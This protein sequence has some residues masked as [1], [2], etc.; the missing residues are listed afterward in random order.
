MHCAVCGVRVSARLAQ[1]D[2][3]ARELLCSAHY[4]A[5]RQQRQQQRQ[6]RARQQH[7][8]TPAE[9]AAAPLARPPPRLSTD[10]PT[11]TDA[12]EAAADAASEA[13]EAEEASSADGE[14]PG[15]TVEGAART[16]QEGAASTRATEVD[17]SSRTSDSS[18]ASEAAGEQTDDTPDWLVQAEVELQAST[19]SAEEALDDWAASDLGP[20]VES[21]TATS[22]GEIAALH[23]LTMRALSAEAALT[24][25]AV[26]ARATAQLADAERA[27]AERVSLAEREAAAGRAAAALESL[28][29]GRAEARAAAALAAA[30][31]S[32]QAAAAERA[33]SQQ[34]SSRLA[35]AE[36]AMAALAPGHDEWRAGKGEAPRSA[37]A[38]GARRDAGMTAR[39]IGVKEEAAVKISAIERAAAEREAAANRVVEETKRQISHREQ[40]MA[41]EKKEVAI[42]AEERIAAAQRKASEWALV[43]V[44]RAAAAAS[45]RIAAEKAAAEKARV[46]QVKAQVAAVERAA[47]AMVAEREAAALRRASAAE[48]A[49][50]VARRET[51]DAQRLAAAQMKALKE[52]AAG[53]LE[54]RI[55]EVQRLALERVAAVEKAA[56]SRAAAMER[57]EGELAA[58]RAAAA[59]AAAAE[60]DAREYSRR[61][62]SRARAAEVPLIDKFEGASSAVSSETRV[63]ASEAQAAG[64]RL[65]TDEQ[66]ALTAEAAAALFAEHEAAAWATAAAAACIEAQG[67]LEAAERSKQQAPGRQ[68]V[69][70]RV[71]EKTAM[72]LSADAAALLIAEQDTETRVGE[73]STVDMA[74]ALR[75]VVQILD[76]LA[77]LLAT[78]NANKG[79]EEY[80]AWRDL[81]TV[82]DA[83]RQRPRDYP[84]GMLALRAPADA[85]ARAL[86]GGETSAGPAAELPLLEYEEDAPSAGGIDEWMT[87]MDG[88]HA[89]AVEAAAEL[90]AD[91]EAPAWATAAA[92]LIEAQEAAEGAEQH[93][94]GRVDM[95]AVDEAAASPDASSAG[96][97]EETAMALSAGVAALLMAEE[98]GEAKVGE[99]DALDV[100]AALTLAVQPGEA[101]AE[102][103]EV[104]SMGDAQA[105]IVDTVAVEQHTLT[106]EAAAALFAEREAFAWAAAA[107][108][109]IEAQEGLEAAGAAKHQA[110]GGP[111][112]GAVSAPTEGPDAVG[113]GVD[114]TASMTLAAGVAALLMAEEDAGGGA[115][116]GDA[117]DEAGALPAA[118]EVELSVEGAKIARQLDEVKTSSRAEEY[119]A[120]RDLTTVE[121]AE[122]QRPRDYPD[123]MLALRAPADAEARAFAGG[124]TSPLLEYEEDAPSA[125]GI[126][127]WMTSTDGQH[128]LAVEAAAEP[129]A[130]GEAPAWATAAAA[131]IEAQ[132]AAEGAKQHAPGRVDM[133]AVD[134]AAASPDAS[135]AG[136]DEETAMALS[137]GV[138]ALLMAEEDGEAK[139]GERDALDVAAAL[140]LAVQ[141]GEASAEGAEVASMGDAQAQIVDTVAVEQHTLTAEAAAALFAEREALAWAAAAAAL[142]EAQEGLEAAGAAKH[143]APGGPLVG[144]VSAPTEGPDAVGAGVDETAS[145]TVAAGVAALLMA[146]EDAGGGAREGDALDEAGALPAAAEVELSVEGEEVA[147]PQ[148]EVTS[149]STESGTQ[150]LSVRRGI[151][152]GR[153]AS[154][155]DGDSVEPV[156]LHLKGAA[157]EHFGMMRR[158]MRSTDATQVV[159]D[160]A[161]AASQGHSTLGQSLDSSD[162]DLMPHPSSTAGPTSNVDVDLAMGMGQSKVAGTRTVSATEGINPKNAARDSEG[163]SVRARKPMTLAVMEMAAKLQAAAE[164]AS[165]IVAA[166]GNAG[167]DCNAVHLSAESFPY[168][169]SSF[170]EGISEMERMMDD[171]AAHRAPELHEKGPDDMSTFDSTWLR[172]L[173]QS[174][175]VRWQKS[176]ENKSRAKNGITSSTQLYLTR[177]RCRDLSSALATMARHASCVRSL[178]FFETQADTHHDR[179]LLGG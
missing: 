102:G 129:F 98:D 174:T 144:A 52:E 44:E 170:P 62:S 25:R 20:T 140:T 128:A 87:S 29:K 132:E 103:A 2:F 161:A 17:F 84:D 130:D 32:A 165:A 114:E 146:E 6:Q 131:L 159:S 5:R 155:R 96:V 160:H 137:A 80:A 107:A 45:E 153:Q 27:A 168:E 70:A 51:E 77:A 167:D 136:V 4:D 108:A 75:P 39:E 8:R 65:T 142:I 127:E 61:V 31:E 57:M 15:A 93:A 145:M 104:A 179:K 112:V 12:G 9:D 92:A 76:K 133:G 106:A 23:Q 3:K 36:A 147:S 157:G 71:D 14:A 118:A 18:G 110:P 11:S 67:G 26:A 101:S 156:M 90:F 49:A 56:L 24:E 175:I 113:A 164:A 53:Q 116:E 138:A 42:R 117:L 50:G 33:L 63:A 97:D 19:G 176:L 37:R 166:T 94:P 89:L 139:V 178:H 100:A 162:L 72:A 105:Q 124:E 151:V 81:T 135:S 91:G 177:R 66:H 48:A 86:A 30:E 109:L 83:E 95:G 46:E 59:V 1:V 150:D 13:E 126:D 69:G 85:E 134:E 7:A 125:G 111:L 10:A 141:P 78:A 163:Q 152:V 143:Q 41:H 120:W 38:V 68:E 58:A 169:L 54:L 121:D 55:A 47:A 34:T 171:R 79:A 40:W 82:E 149:P 60:R 88:Q 172:Q 154:V 158:L 64:R 122:R 73:G 148:D 28:A 21:W 22:F 115:R 16:A 173:K 74:N 99:R 123:G 35:A 43:E 119:A